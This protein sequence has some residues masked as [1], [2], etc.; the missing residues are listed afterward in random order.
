MSEE[1]TLVALKMRCERL[2]GVSIY[3]FMIPDCTSSESEGIE[4]CCEIRC[5]LCDGYYS[6]AVSTTF[7]FE[8]SALRY[9]W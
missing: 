4:Q 6:I 7:W 3:L 5:T 8:S 9:L 1:R 2:C